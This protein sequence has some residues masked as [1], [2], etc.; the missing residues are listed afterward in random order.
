MKC[1]KDGIQT[2]GEGE[3]E[4]WKEKDGIQTLFASVRVI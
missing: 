4:G 3:G 1:E 2:E